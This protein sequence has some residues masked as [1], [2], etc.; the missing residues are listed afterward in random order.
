MNLELSHR[1]GQA[2]NGRDVGLDERDRLVEAAQTARTFEDLPA[3]VQRL[4][5][6]I[7]ARPLGGGGVAKADWDEAAHPRGPGGEWVDKLVA[8]VK[9]EHPGVKLDL[10]RASAG[11]VVLSRIVTPQRSQGTGSKIM[12]R[13]VDEA[14]R[15]GHT[16]ALT[17]SGDFGGSPARLKRFYARFGFV[18]NKGRNRDYEI[19]E[20]MLRPPGGR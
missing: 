10:H 11:H 18:P 20:D 3:D 6:E 14:D 1:L 16:L 12:R 5:L 9:A 19:S 2:M 8:E 17:P 13:I 15:H 4:V 7:E